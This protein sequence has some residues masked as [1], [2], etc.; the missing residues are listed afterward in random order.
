MLLRKAQVSD[1]ASVCPDM[2]ILRSLTPALGAALAFALPASAGAV[3]HLPTIERTLSASKSSASCTPAATDSTTYR[4]PLAGF[5]TTRLHGA[6][7]WD[8]YVNDAAS[9]RVLAQSRAFGSQEV[10]Q[11]WV[12]AGQKVVITA[13]R[14]AGSASSIGV[15]IDFA[16][17][18]KPAPTTS[19]VVRIG[20]VSQKT[21]TGLE[22]AGFDVTHNIQKNYID[23]FMDSS[24]KLD[25]F[26]K[27]GIPF[28]MHVADLAAKDAKARAAEARRQ[29]LGVRSAVPSGRNTYRSLA[30]YQTEMKAITDAHPDLAKP[31]T[32]GTTYQGRPIQGIEFS[33]NVNAVDDGKPTFFL[34]GVHHAREW[35]SAEIAM[36]FARLLSDSY[37]KTDADGTRITNVLNNER[38][39][40]V[41]IINVDGFVASRGENATGTPIPDAEDEAGFNGVAE[42]IALGGA[43]AYRRK[44]CDGAVPSAEALNGPARNVPCYYQYGVDPNRNYG[45]DWGGPGASN[46]PTTQVY[47]GT[48]Q[49]S[50]PETQAVWHTSQ[51]RP[52]TVLVT[53]HT[54]AALVLR[55]PGL[56]TNGK[57][58]D[59]TLLKELGDKMAKVTGYKSQFGFELYDTTGTTEDWNYGAVGA[60][61]YTIEIGPSGG[62]FHGDYKTA[63]ENQWIGKVG[64]KTLG[65][66]KEALLT[67]AAYAMDP[68]THPIISGTGTPGAELELKKSFVTDSSPICTV[69]QGFVTVQ[70]DGTPVDCAA[71]G[72]VFGV[73]HAQDGLN[74]KTVVKP[75]G[76]FT[77]H[78]TQSTRP[79][80]GY[81]YDEATKK[82]VANDKPRELWTLTCKATGKTQQFAIERGEQRDLGDVCA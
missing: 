34:M 48:G 4:A 45:F 63:V 41:P 2:S 31:I 42:P 32:I 17:A 29:R 25:A 23:I 12:D 68:K 39:I 15:A 74:Y 82:P 76:T 80:Q 30:N 58:P 1:R 3:V 36:E 64:S 69:A 62:D 22:Q 21:F 60:L 72:A 44:N 57:A 14:T 46:D 66:M 28:K 37:G 38:I 50:E 7:E 51:N 61:G 49:W 19:S 10:A 77:W 78:I 16:D 71:P 6:G 81:K 53:M 59:E 13:C 24:A 18:V 67:S 9:K 79:F 75:D 54:I 73:T 56:H 5:L 35:P 26:R 70:G 47:R 43:F 65:G 27:L 55:S 33:Q 11:H 52:V 20:R 8:L 40:V